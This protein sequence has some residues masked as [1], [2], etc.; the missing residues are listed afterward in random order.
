MGT[1]NQIGQLFLLDKSIDL[2]LK[3]LYLGFELLVLFITATDNCL[4]QGHQSF[5]LLFELPIDLLLHL[6]QFS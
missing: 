5:F 6:R 4:K 2:G 1:L 3:R